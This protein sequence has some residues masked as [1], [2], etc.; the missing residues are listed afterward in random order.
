MSDLVQLPDFDAVQRA[1]G[2]INAAE[3]HGLLCGMLCRQP[4]TDS[5]TWLQQLQ[6][7]CSAAAALERPPLLELFAATCAQLADEELGFQ[8]LLPA[9]SVHL[10]ER[11]DCLGGW[12]QGFLFGLGLGGALSQPLDAEAREFLGDLNKIAQIGFDTDE[13]DDADELAYAEIVEYVR[14]GVLLVRQELLPEPPSAH[15]SDRLH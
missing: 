6:Q 15:R 4:T 10:R 7:E 3:A 9:D 12:C 1:A 14:M 11:A 5:A 2:G 13:T 8:L